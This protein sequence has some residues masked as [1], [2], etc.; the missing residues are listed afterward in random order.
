MVTNQEEYLKYLAI[1]LK[2]IVITENI[3]DQSIL[4]KIKSAISVL[5]DKNIPYNKKTPSIILAEELKSRYEEKKY[6]EHI[7][8]LILF[9]ENALSIKDLGE[10]ELKEQIEEIINILKNDKI[11]LNKRKETLVIAENLK[12][13][14]ELL[15]N[16]KVKQ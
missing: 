1:V 8:N 13:Q 3:G 6:K 4:K 16:K 9:F 2:K 5:E 15:N 11:P 14:V 10:H 7:N 12:P